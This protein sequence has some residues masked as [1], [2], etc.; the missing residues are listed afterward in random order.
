MCV[1]AKH[2]SAGEGERV[3]EIHR[4]IETEIREMNG[5]TWGANFGINFAGQCIACSDT[6]GV[7]RE[8]DTRHRCQP[9]H[10][11]DKHRAG[12]RGLVSRRL[13]WEIPTT[14]IRIVVHLNRKGRRDN[15]LN[16]Q[17]RLNLP[18]QCIASAA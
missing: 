14:I 8:R 9:F 6:E 5:I 13:L 18:F 4:E 15:L 7:D 2:S 12:E 11:L 17:S 16:G 1:A 3:D 10:C